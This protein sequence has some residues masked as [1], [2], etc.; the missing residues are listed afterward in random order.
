MNAAADFLAPGLLVDGGP[1]RFVIQVERMLWHLGF[2]DVRNID[3]SGDEGGDI[4]ALKDRERWA[5]QCKWRKAG[6]TGKVDESA[7]RETEQAARAYRCER[8][9]LVTNA[10]L[11]RN[12]RARVK[13]AQRLQRLDVVD[14]EALLAIARSIPQSMPSR[15]TLHRYQQEAADK[16]VARL[17]ET[18]RA[19]LILATG[20]GKTVVAGEVVRR[21]IDTAPD[22]QVLVVAHMKDL[23]A[24]LER[25]LWR[26]LPK[27]VPTHLLTG[28]IKP[29]HA[30]GVTFA[31]VASALGAVRDGY[32][33][34][35][36]VVD[37]T[38]HVG[39]TG[40]FSELLETLD[41]ARQVGVT[42]TPWRGDRYDIEHRFGPAVYKLGIADGMRRGHLAQVDYKL[43]SDNID[44]DFVRQVSEHDYSVG[45]LNRKLFLPQRDDAVGEHLLHAWHATPSPRAIVFCATIDH[46]ERLVI[47]LRRTWPGWRRSAVL[48]SGMPRRD[49]DLILAEFRRGDVP[50][51]CAVD[52]LNEGVDVPDVNLIVF[53]RVTHSR[54]IFVQQLGRG[55]RVR[56][57]KDRVTVLDFVADIRRIAAAMDLRAKL[58]GE[59]E[60]VVVPSRIGFSDA[61]AEELMKEWIKDAASL[62]TANDEARLNF[63]DPYA[64]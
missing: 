47:A 53:L 29:V 23:V 26:H 21:H 1:H 33:P 19:L 10:R 2:T 45:E 5:V 44:W 41:G 24:Q 50:I 30:R 31:T 55:L 64:S 38:H 18:G 42:A 16:V 6:P 40:L 58:A 8:A 61:Q 34:G 4:L 35:L 51:V 22:Q 59:P 11:D 39:A 56:E 17:E 48:H 37:E 62:E 28:D 27:E 49:R 43:Y 14:A 3:G 25:G 13:R 36:V 57:G 60:E 7:V 52:V 46:A 54:R 12:A 63:P 32:A 9:L 15:Y 20:L